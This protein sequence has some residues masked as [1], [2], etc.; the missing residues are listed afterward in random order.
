MSNNNLNIPFDSLEHAI[1]GSIV[2]PPGGRF[3]PRIQ[4][5]VQIVMLYT[6]E[7]NVTID[8]RHIQVL[9]GQLILLKPGHEETFIFSKT[10]QS[11]HRWIAVHVTELSDETRKTLYQL[12][13][14]LALTEEMNRLTD[15]MLAVLRHVSNDDSAILSLG[16]AAIHLY[17]IESKRVLLQKEKHPAVYATLTWIHEHYAEEISLEKLAVQSNLSAEHLLRLFKTNVQ[18]TPIHYLWE[19]R[20]NKSVELLTSTGLTVSE[21]AHRCG[22]K[23]SHHFARLIKKFTGK[24]ATE[25][26]Q[27]SWSDLRK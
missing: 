10:E 1:A 7:M 16:L 12:P 14:C 11:W 25:I 22:F 26:R 17:P 13:E 4:Q 5:D 21:I 8:G 19:Y 23:T 6:G 18:S 2:Y 27:L 24:T 9:P 15:L 20:V 3:G